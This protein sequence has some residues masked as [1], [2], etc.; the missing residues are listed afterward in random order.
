M[1]KISFETPAQ[2]RHRGW[3]AGLAVAG[4]VAGGFLQGTA[5]LAPVRAKLQERQFR[6]GEQDVTKLHYLLLHHGEL[7]NSKLTGLPSS[8]AVPPEFLRDGLPTISLVSDEAGLYSP[9]FGIIA[10]GWE[11][12]RRWERATFLSYFENG[13]LRYETPAGLRVH[14]GQSRG[15]DIKSFALIFRRTYSG[16]PRAQRGVFFDGQSDA[17]QRLVLSNTDKP[18]RFLNA[19]ALDIADRVGCLTSRSQPVRVF[20]NGERIESGYFALEHQSREFLR[21]RFGH[22]DFQWVR[23][24]G[25]SPP[26]LKFDLLESWVNVWRHGVN[27]ESAAERFDLDDLCAWVFAVT[28]CHTTDEDQGGYFLDEHRPEALWRT[29]VWDMDGSF[30]HGKRVKKQKF[31]MERLRG[32]RARLFRRLCENDPAFRVRFR[33]FAEGVLNERMNAAARRELVEKYRRL[34]ATDIFV[35]ERKDLTGKLDEAER[36]LNARAEM[37]LGELDRYYASLLLP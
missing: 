27:L 26:S 18:K 8:T 1:P 10:N 17:I 3:L 34:L 11:K 4:I 30:N 24:K 16:A 6:V 32:F 9:D 19:L 29:L 15:G 31:D 28:L 2:T 20:L 14:G 7:P 35:H 5:A 33:A 21:H 37:Y 12:G 23:L 36:F 22:D 25:N 13:E